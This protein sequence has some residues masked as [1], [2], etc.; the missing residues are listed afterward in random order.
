MPP[1]D[2]GDH[3]PA[4]RVTTRLG[5]RNADLFGK[6]RAVSHIVRLVVF[7]TLKMVTVLWLRKRDAPFTETCVGG[8]GSMAET[9]TR[10]ISRRFGVRATGRDLAGQTAPPSNGQYARSS[11]CDA[12]FC[13]TPACGFESI[14]DVQV[15]PRILR[16][17]AVERRAMPPPCVHQGRARLVNELVGRGSGHS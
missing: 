3:R 11:L 10:G 17:S 4:F 15:D 12:A 16:P 1:G 7:G 9:M 8:D 13:C 6:R 5:N 14:V 2:P